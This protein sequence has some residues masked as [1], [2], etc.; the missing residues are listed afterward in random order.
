MFRLFKK[1]DQR[2]VVEAAKYVKD[3]CSEVECAECMFWDSCGCKFGAVPATWRVNGKEDE[4]GE[5]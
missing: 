5:E 1:A 3:Y 4:N 2:K